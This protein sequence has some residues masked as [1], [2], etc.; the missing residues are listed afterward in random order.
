MSPSPR[1]FVR[2]IAYQTPILR[3]VLNDRRDLRLNLQLAAQKISNLEGCL[4]Q[5]KSNFEVMQNRL[6]ELRDLKIL[7]KKQSDKIDQLADTLTKNNSEFTDIQNENVIRINSLI[8]ILKN[9]SIVEKNIKNGIDQENISDLNDYEIKLYQELS[10]FSEDINVHNLP[11]IFHYWS[12]KHLRPMLEEIGCSGVNQFYAKYLFE[13]AQLTLPPHRFVSIGAGNGDVEIDIAKLLIAMGLTDF[14]IECLEYNPSMIE[15]GRAEARAQ[16]VGRVMEF[17]QADFNKWAP[18]QTYSAIMANH[19][20]HHVVNLEG[21][22]DTIKQALRPGGYF[23]TGDMVGRNG[24]Q[25]WPEARVVVDQFWNE[26]SERYHYNHQLKRDEPIYVDH[27]CSSEGF[28]GI[29]AQDIMPLL[30]E[31]FHFKVFIGFLNAISPFI[32][33]SFGHNFDQGNPEDCAFID[34][35]HEADENGFKSGILKPTQIFAVMSV[36]PVSDLFYSR[37]LSP[38]F[39]VREP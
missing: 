6:D 15:R 1:D 18:S 4:E 26:L 32:D 25:R 2:E 33:R 23:V 20:L 28:E 21:L 38:E 11:D 27:D 24:H 14:T 37:G 31:K 12:N 19:S 16:G 13:S 10:I 9:I 8:E 35:V 39:S 5:S 17:T 7:I 34:R 30:I 3:R 29:R 22:F 36:I